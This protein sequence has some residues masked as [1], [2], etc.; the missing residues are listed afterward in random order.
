M[1]HIPPAHIR[2]H[3]AWHIIVILVVIVCSLTACD[4]AFAADT[5]T[6]TPAASSSTHDAPSPPPPALLIHTLT[7]NNFLAD[8]VYP[9][10]DGLLLA[11]NPGP[12][13]Q[14]PGSGAEGAGAPALYF[15]D[16]TTQQ[17]RIRATPTSAPDGTPR[18]I[19]ES[20]AAGHWLAFIVADAGYAHWSLQAINTQTGEQRLID[21]YLQE[22]SAPGV[23][24]L[25]ALALDGVDL[26]W[27]ASVPTTGASSFVLKMYHFATQQTRVLLSGPQTPTVA[28]L[29]ISNGTL[30]LRERH[31]TQGPS[32]GVYLWNLSEPAAQQIST[33]Q[34]LS[35]ALSEH[36]AVWDLPQ[37]RT[38]SAYNRDTH[39]L[40]E[41]WGRR[42]LRPAIAQ[43]R[44]YVVCLNF[45]E[46]QMILVHV[47]S[48]QETP[49]G[50]AGIGNKGTVANGRAYWVQPGAT[51]PATNT[52]DYVDLPAK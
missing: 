18:G 16:F 35:G 25:G 8:A 5:P 23:S 10:Q 36:F 41:S 43:D 46:E 33:D 12:A 30:L 24:F 40:L 31:A 51:G 9:N 2:T 50:A 21:S 27:S 47:P 19:T 49:L 39:T 15:Y 37:D 3:H 26:A 45:N 28:P 22:G 11:G 17:I 4:G 7:L 1:M 34:P 6:S 48:G 44:P 32:D 38:L 42:C 29:A 13:H 14:T 20:V 52:V